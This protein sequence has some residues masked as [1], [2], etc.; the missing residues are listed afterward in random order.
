MAV[1]DRFTAVEPGVCT[2][3]M[4]VAVEFPAGVGVAPT[5][6]GASRAPATSVPTTATTNRIGPQGFELAI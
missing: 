2:V 4:G 6:T 3:E 5:M 1:A